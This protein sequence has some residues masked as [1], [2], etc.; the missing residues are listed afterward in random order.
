MSAVSRGPFDGRRKRNLLFLGGHGRNDLQPPPRQLQDDVTGT[1]VLTV[2]HGGNVTFNGAYWD[3]IDPTSEDVTSILIS[4]LNTEEER[5][6]LN[7]LLIP[8]V[9]TEVVGD[10]GCNLK[11]VSV[12]SDDDG[13]DG[14]EDVVVDTMIESVNN[15]T[16]TITDPVPIIQVEEK[17]E[18]PI[19]TSSE[20]ISPSSDKKSDKSS[21]KW[22]IPVVVGSAL[23]AFALVSLLYIKKRSSTKN[24]NVD[25]DDVVV[26]ASK[27]ADSDDMGEGMEVDLEGNVGEG[28]KNRQPRPPAVWS[29]AYDAITSPTSSSLRSSSK[30]E[31]SSAAANA[32]V[33]GAAAVIA[34]TASKSSTQEESKAT[35]KG[36]MNT[37]SPNNTSSNKKTKNIDSI[38]DDFSDGDSSFISD[39]SAATSTRDHDSVN[40]T[41]VLSGM[42]GLSGILADAPPLDDVTRNVSGFSRLSVSTDGSTNNNNG[43]GGGGGYLP[44]SLSSPRSP[45]K[46]ATSKKDCSCP[47]SNLRKQESFEGT[48]R[49][50]SAMA[51][52]N[53]KKDILHV[54]CDTHDAPTEGG[55]TDAATGGLTTNEPGGDKTPLLMSASA[56]AA[57]AAASSSSSSSSSLGYGMSRRTISAKKHTSM[58]EKQRLAEKLS[59]KSYGTSSSSSSKKLKNKKQQGMSKLQKEEEE[60]RNANDEKDLI[61]PVNFQRSD[62]IV[63]QGG[64]SNDGSEDD[65]V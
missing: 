17:E 9:C 54:A 50:R 63:D 46:D 3:N 7:E 20:N 19:E 21:K 28:G 58:I 40:D 35:S 1:A 16:P 23:V 12:T 37:P 15:E 26:K 42:S 10:G 53:L 60:E 38:L 64:S 25:D 51:K 32:A 59:L 61:L 14:G 2:A 36:S 29:N 57:G 48:Y 33:A 24:N 47:S 41:S 4:A 39:S 56:T 5:N 30:Q 43:A 49:T 18:A 22:I 45:T 11:V 62:S 65:L 27:T 6:K 31:A 8:L 44:K 34:A 13:L 55:E 52:L